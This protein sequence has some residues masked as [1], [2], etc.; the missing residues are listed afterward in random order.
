M[1]SLNRKLLYTT[2][3][4]V[5]FSWET[6]QHMTF[7]LTSNPP[8]PN[9]YPTGMNWRYFF[10]LVLCLIFGKFGRKDPFWIDWIS[11]LAEII[12]TWMMQAQGLPSK[13]WVSRLKELYFKRFLLNAL[14]NG[15]V[16]LYGN[17]QLTG[18]FL[19]YLQKGMRSGCIQN[20]D[21]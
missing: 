3:V 2:T 9:H 15:R 13:V 12:C 6:C 16:H 19:A 5:I 17:F 10:M 8:P 18:G 20:I 1:A 21:L 11:S 14:H 4:V 7:L